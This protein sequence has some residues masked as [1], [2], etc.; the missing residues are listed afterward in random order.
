MSMRVA[1]IVIALLMG[2]SAC[3]ELKTAGRT[4]GHTTKEVT[5]DI[6]HATRDAATEVG[7]GAKRVANEVTKDDSE[8]KEEEK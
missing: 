4:I 6:G 2:C 7:K 3:A 1:A 5:T 8:S